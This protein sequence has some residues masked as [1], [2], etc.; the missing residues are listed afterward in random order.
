MDMPPGFS[1]AGVTE[2]QDALRLDLDWY[3]GGIESPGQLGSVINACA[4]VAAGLANHVLCFRTVWEATAQGDQGRAS[5]TMGGGGGGGG[6]RVGGFMQWT[7]PFGAPSAANWIAH[8]GAR[9]TSTSS[10]RRA[11][12][13]RGSRSTR[14]ATPTLQPEGDLP[15]ADDA[16]RLPRRAH[17]LDAVL[18]VRLRRARRRVAPR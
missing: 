10:A 4:A 14:A 17:D 13:S 5:V 15:R 16:R 7:L 3:A 11:S 2:L 18:P 12:S 6:C 1:G 8:D 9:A